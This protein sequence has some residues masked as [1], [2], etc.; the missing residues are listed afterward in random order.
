[1]FR[2]CAGPEYTPPHL[3]KTV[4]AALATVGANFQYPPINWNAVL[5][6][7]MRLKFG[8]FPVNDS[9]YYFKML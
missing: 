9:C 5:S 1:M 4:I 2:F 7:L 6:P 3:V 8:E